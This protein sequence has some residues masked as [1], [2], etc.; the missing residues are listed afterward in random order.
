MI[1]MRQKNSWCKSQERFLL[2]DKHREKHKKHVRTLFW[3]RRRRREETLQK[4]RTTTVCSRRWTPCDWRESLRDE[5]RGIERETRKEREEVRREKKKER[6][7]RNRLWCQAIRRR[8]YSVIDAMRRLP[9]VLKET[10]LSHLWD[11]ALIESS[12]VRAN[13]VKWR[14]LI[15]VMKLPLLSFNGQEKKRMKREGWRTRKGRRGRQ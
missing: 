10:L 7:G 13:C 12:Q 9:E 5:S 4:Q 8:D 11:E 1:R 14:P 2:R 15:E 6:E 3:T